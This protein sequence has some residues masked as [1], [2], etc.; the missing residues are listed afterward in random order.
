MNV[1]MK[2][3]DS[4]MTAPSKQWEIG[5]LRIVSLLRY[6][7]NI[8]CLTKY[9]RTRSGRANNR[10]KT[11]AVNKYPETNSLLKKYTCK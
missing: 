7:N 2:R 11:A 1:P 4:D 8:M 3:I 10:S 5:V 9:A 6:C